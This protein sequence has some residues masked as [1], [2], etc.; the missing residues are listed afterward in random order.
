MGDISVLYVS[1]V[2]LWP[3]MG[4]VVHTH[5]YWHFSIGLNG[6]VQ[7]LDGKVSAEYPS[8]N[9]NPPG[10]PHSGMVCVE[11]QRSINVMFFVNDRK[12]EKQME[13][14]DFESLRPEAIHRD[15]LERIADQID[16]LKPSQEFLDAAVSYYFHLVME[17]AQNTY[18]EEAPKLLADRALDFIEQNYMKQLRLEDVAEYIDRTKSYTSYLVSN[19]TGQTVV[20]HLNAVR[21]KHACTLLAYSDT[22]VDHVSEVCGF[23]NVKNFCRVFKNIVGTTPT[24]YRTSHVTEDM[25][26][27]GDLKDLDA[28]YGHLS[29][30]YVP[31]ARKCVSS[32][33]SSLCTPKGRVRKGRASPPLRS[34]A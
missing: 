2:T 13:N 17:S 3:G 33:F 14:F 22:S 32:S 11:E 1:K 16:K 6:K 9:C 30:T 5:D 21:I 26:Y 4:N 10:Q 31:S 20:E 8:C 15:V 27:D 29:Y 7:G 23:T 19:T 28:P 25:R 18:T 12:L 34:S 24:R